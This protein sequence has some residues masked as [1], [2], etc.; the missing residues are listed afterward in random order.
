MKNLFI[1]LINIIIISSLSLFIVSCFR[2]KENKYMIPVNFKKYFYFNTGSWWVYKNQSGKYDTLK[3]TSSNSKFKNMLEN[4][5]LYEKITIDYNSTDNGEMKAS[6]TFYQ[7]D[8]FFF[9]FY[10]IDKSF[11]SNI[12]T[13]TAVYDSDFGLPA[14]NSKIGWQI[15]DSLKIDGDIYYDIYIVNTYDA[16]NITNNYPIKCY[17]S[18]NIGLIKKELKNGE[19]WELVDYKINK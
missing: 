6:T 1:K 5:N 12:A 7:D 8:I 9:C 11:F 2:G 10:G 19:V 15:L 16:A 13:N 17:F 18:P 3:I 4:D 14:C